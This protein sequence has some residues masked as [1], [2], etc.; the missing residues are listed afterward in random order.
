MAVSAA[1]KAAAKIAATLEKK[2]AAKKAAAANARGLKAA[3]KPSLAKSVTKK[4]PSALSIK[5]GKKM[6]PSGVPTMPKGKK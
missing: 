6:Y 2:N 1:L 4:S 5:I 3:N